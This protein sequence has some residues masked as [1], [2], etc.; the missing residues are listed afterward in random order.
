MEAA[1]F[2]VCEHYP[3]QDVKSHL[4]SVSLCFCLEASYWAT[5]RKRG[6]TLAGLRQ[7]LQTT[8][9]GRPAG[10][11]NWEHGSEGPLPCLLGRS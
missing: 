4:I 2:Q 10:H 8:P 5:V 6:I 7:R 1:N 11:G 9:E 3:R